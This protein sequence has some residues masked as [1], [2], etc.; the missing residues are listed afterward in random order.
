[1]GICGSG[2]R[3]RDKYLCH[4][5]LKSGNSQSWKCSQ[6]NLKKNIDETFKKYDVNHNGRL[7]KEEVMNLLKEGDK[8][9]ARKH[10]D[11]SI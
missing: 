4:R 1:M 9:K 11:S 6:E 7:S 5:S 2:E 10:S 3:K 8:K